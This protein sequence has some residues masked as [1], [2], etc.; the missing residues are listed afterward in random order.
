MYHQYAKYDSN[1]N[2]Y[3]LLKIVRSSLMGLVGHR[4]SIG[5][6]EMTWSTAGREEALETMVGLQDEELGSQ[7][8]L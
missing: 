1:T 3:Y 4:F 2:I 5:G 8:W 7:K 6:F